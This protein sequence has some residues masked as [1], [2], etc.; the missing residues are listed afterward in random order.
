[1]DVDAVLDRLQGDLFVPLLLGLG[2]AFAYLAILA[3]AHRQARALVLL[4]RA[5]RRRLSEEERRER[6]LGYSPALARLRRLDA[7]LTRRLAR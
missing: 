6:L 2:A 7:E 4:A 5:C 3:V 1:M